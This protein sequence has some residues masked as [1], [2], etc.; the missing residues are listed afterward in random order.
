MSP[1]L[2]KMR[3]E[4]TS[5]FGYRLARASANFQC[6]V[7]GCPSSSPVAASP[8]APLQIDAIRRA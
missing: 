2:V 1:C 6:V 7:A 3:S 8:N 5:T 4:S